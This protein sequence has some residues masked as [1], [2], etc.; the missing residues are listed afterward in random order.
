MCI[1]HA[2]KWYTQTPCDISWCPKLE[3]LIIADSLAYINI[4]WYLRKSAKDAKTSTFITLIFS[5]LNLNFSYI[6]CNWFSGEWPRQGNCCSTE[7]SPEGSW[8]FWDCR[9]PGG[10]IL[11]EIGCSVVP[12]K[13]L[14]GLFK[15]RQTINNSCVRKYCNRTCQILLL[16]LLLFCGVFTYWGKHE[17]SW[18]CDWPSWSPNCVLVICELPFVKNAAWTLTRWKTGLKPRLLDKIKSWFISI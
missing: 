8:S 11:R 12:F 14:A 5:Y 1:F 9:H 6:L 17:S 7:A 16:I 13:W 3:S 15:G 18:N 4:V 2:F 10:A